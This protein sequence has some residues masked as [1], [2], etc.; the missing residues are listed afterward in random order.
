MMAG[1]SKEPGANARFIGVPSARTRLSM[2]DLLLDLDAL[3]CNIATM[4]AHVRAAGI[5]LR[6]HAKVR[7]GVGKGAR[8]NGDRRPFA[9][10]DNDD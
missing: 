8:W 4:S 1:Q 10:I 5:N 9:P 2:P 6:P 3:E 7:F